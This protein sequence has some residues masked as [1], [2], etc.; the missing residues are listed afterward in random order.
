MPIKCVAVDDEPLALALMRNYITATPQ[1]ALLQTFEDAIAA[2]EFIRKHDVELLLLDID[3]PDISGIDLMHALEKK[4]MVIFT[5]A[6]R[7]YA[8]EGFELNAIDYLLKPIDYPR[9]KVAIQKAVEYQ[10][11]KKQKGQSDAGHIFVYVEYKLLKIELAHVTYMESLEDYIKI[12]FDNGPTVMTLM[13]MK[14]ML[15]RLPPDQFRRIHR[16]FIVPVAKVRAINNRKAELSSGDV[17]PISD[18]YQDF[19]A[20]WKGQ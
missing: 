1:L 19:I 6:Y 9:F 15:E 4:P 2:A 17:L 3:M 20:F 18:S 12:H 13:S 10:E 14:K 7:N 16:S 8:V 11:Y 5:T